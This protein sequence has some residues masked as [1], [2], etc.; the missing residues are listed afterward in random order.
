M[1][2]R[3]E[4]ENWK[5]EPLTNDAMF[6]MVFLNNEKAR[7]GLVSVLLGIPESEIQ[8][9]EVMNPM[10]FPDAFDAKQTVL[11]LRLHLNDNSYLNLEMQVRRFPHW[12]NRV[13][14][15][16]CRQITEQSRVEGF[17][18]DSL[19][20]VIHV[21]IM[22]HTL[23]TGH[24]RFFTKYE[25]QDKDGYLYTDKL[26]FYVM[27]LKAIAEASEE[28]RN[29]GLTAWGEAFSAKNWDQIKG[30]N[31][32]GVKE[33]VKQMEV[34]M[35]TPQQRDMVWRRKLAELDYNSQMKSAM[36]EAKAEGLAEGEKRLTELLGKLFAQGRVEEAERAV[37][38]Q[39]YRESLYLQYNIGWERTDDNQ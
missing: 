16:S 37:A 4:K 1:K 5:F 3:Q 33:A 2:E 17:D 29:S 25:V 7:K 10:Q 11:D 18:Y 38:E 6:H 27:D 20:P 35:E 36:K 19:E 22:D 34:I 26:Q 39:A 24:K 13:V 15:Y 28:E 14:V 12:T 32:E 30:I 23:F 31:N 9:A 21:A 8:D